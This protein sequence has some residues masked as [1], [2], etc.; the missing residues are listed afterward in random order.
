MSVNRVILIGNVGNDPEIKY[1]NDDNPVARISLT[2]SESYKKK[3]GEKTTE[4]QW[5][6]VLLWRGLAKVV[7]KWVKK[8]DKLYIE[9]KVTYK[10]WQ[11]KEGNNRI[12][13]EIIASNMTMLGGK[14]ETTPENKPE[15]KQSQENT[16]NQ[17]E[18]DLPF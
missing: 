11:D 9:G 6:T 15:S 13:T 14:K 16:T 8:G 17:G 12:S 7:E 4:T 18:D 1:V 10:K 3:S 5:H 2:T